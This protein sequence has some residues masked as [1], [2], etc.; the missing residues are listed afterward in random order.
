MTRGVRLALY[1]VVGLLLGGWIVVANAETIA[2]TSSVETAKQGYGVNPWY[3]TAELGCKAYLS[4][5]YPSYSY[6]KYVAGSNGWQFTCYGLNANGASVGL[7]SIRLATY[8]PSTPSI[9]QNGV[10]SMT[11]TGTV[12]TC[13]SGQG[14][15]LSGSTCTRDNCPEGQTRQSDG[16]CVPSCES[17]SSVLNGQCVSDVCPDGSPRSSGTTCRGQ[18]CISSNNSEFS[19]QPSSL[20]ASVKDV[21][22]N[23][24]CWTSW[25]VSDE[26]SQRRPSLRGACD[27]SAPPEDKECA[28]GMVKQT[29]GATTKCYPEEG[30]CPSKGMC[31][32]KVNNVTVCIACSPG[33]ET[34]TPV[35]GGTKTETVNGDGT[36]TQISEFGSGSETKTETKTTNPD[37]STSTSGVGTGTKKT[38]T[39]TGDT[40]TTKTETTTTITNPDGTTSTSV[41][42]TTETS[43]KGT[44]CEKNPKSQ[45]C[46][47]EASGDDIDFGNVPEEGA[48]TEQSRGVQ[49]VTVIDLP[50][51]AS[52]PS[53][54]RLPVGSLS[55]GPICDAAS[56]LKPLILA[57]AWLSAGLIVIGGKGD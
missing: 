3:A 26:G 22:G 7:A 35:P 5:T 44:Y 46:T 17:G 38:T 39:C 28:A 53:D 10:V 29:V 2:A 40:C 11:C 9:Y 8:C 49:S 52:C 50:S 42:V 32:G 31:S 54:I 16:S 14:W 20:G 48:L 47:G 43:D 56:W 55:W 12:Y 6:D 13:P 19:S 36:K 4:S 51:N 33:T 21:C 23:N 37:G 1:F 24:G 57:F 15:V 30:T 18:A 45:A 41:G 25:W 27:P 34:K